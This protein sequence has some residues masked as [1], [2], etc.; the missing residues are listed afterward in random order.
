MSILKSWGVGLQHINSG[1]TIQPITPCV[2]RECE[3]VHAYECECVHAYVV[4]VCDYSAVLSVKGTRK[5][6]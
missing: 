5:Q 1:G 3:C 2:E 6:C 4:C